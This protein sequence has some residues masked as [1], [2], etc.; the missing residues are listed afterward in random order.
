MPKTGRTRGSFQP[1]VNDDYSLCRYKVM[2]V[3]RH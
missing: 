1:L 3:G 2:P